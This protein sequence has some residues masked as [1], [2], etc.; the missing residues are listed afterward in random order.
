MRTAMR[1]KLPLV[2]PLVQV[3]AAAALTA[4]YF[5]RRDG[6]LA[7]MQPDIQL[8]HALNAPATLIKQLFLGTAHAWLPQFYPSVDYVVDTVVYFP[9]IWLIWYLVSVE[10]GGA[11]YSILTPKTRMRGTVDIAAIVF[12]TMLAVFGL[13]VCSEFRHVPAYACCLAI[14]YLIWSLAIVVFYGHDLRASFGAARPADR[15]Q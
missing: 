12:G 1:T 10:I 15:I 13:L 7:K 4:S 3:V 8:C 6:T 2:L 11:G 9:L 14:P 5:V